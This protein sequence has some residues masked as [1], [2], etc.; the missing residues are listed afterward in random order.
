MVPI[1]DSDNAWIQL[2]SLQQELGHISVDD[3]TVVLDG[4][5]DKYWELGSSQQVCSTCSSRCIKTS[6]KAQI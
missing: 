2:V 3:A 6:N 5:Q 1:I 4:L